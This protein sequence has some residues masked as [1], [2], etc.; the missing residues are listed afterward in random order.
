MDSVDR[1]L[2]VY[3]SSILFPARFRRS[4]SIPEPADLSSGGGSILRPVSVQHR[5]G[6]GGKATEAR[7]RAF[8]ERHV[9]QPL[10]RTDA[11][12]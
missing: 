5:C 7:L 4:G 12:G 10:R 6:S 3:R 2:S 11:D 1:C 8:I 9:V